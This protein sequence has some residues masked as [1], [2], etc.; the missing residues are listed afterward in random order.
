MSQLPSSFCLLVEFQV[1]IRLPKEILWKNKNG[2]T[3]IIKM[4]MSIYEWRTAFK[5]SKR[6]TNTLLSSFLASTSKFTTLL[7]F[8]SS[9]LIYSRK[10]RKTKEKSKQPNNTVTF[11]CSSLCHSLWW[12]LFLQG[13]CSSTQAVGSVFYST[14]P[15]SKKKASKLMKKKRPRQKIWR[16]VQRSSLQTTRQITSK[17][18]R[19]NEHLGSD[20]TE[21]E[22]A[23]TSYLGCSFLISNMV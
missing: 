22:N 21:R 4:Q 14:Q 19:Q 9:A 16:R 3:P 5:L 18:I 13:T 6:I 1:R 2:T 12:F 20:Y 10:K 11:L 17:T 8:I 7:S 15:K 23:A